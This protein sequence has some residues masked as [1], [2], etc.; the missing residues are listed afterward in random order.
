ME[1]LMSNTTVDTPPR[2]WPLFLAGVL[3]FVLGPVIYFV[4]SSQFGYM[5][6]PW[7][8]LILAAVGVLC[9]VISVCQRGGILR[10]AGLVLFVLLCGLEW[11]FMLVVTKTPPYEGPAQPGHK[12]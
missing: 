8:M 11:F 10:S 3:L 12:V 2:R 1:N 5:K 4:Q 7:H 6:M 9:M